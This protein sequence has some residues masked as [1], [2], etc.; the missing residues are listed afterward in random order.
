MGWF[1]VR[2]LPLGI[3]SF[4]KIVESNC[5][6]VDKTQFI[7]ELINSESYYFLS[8]PRRFGKSLLLDTLAEV[9]NGGKELFKGLWIYDSGYS[10]EEHPVLRI[11]MSNIANE[12]PETLKNE[13]MI[14][15]GRRAIQEGLS[16]DVET[17][18]AM[19]KTLIEELCSK[20]SQRVVVL[21]DEYD[22]PVLDNLHDLGIAEANRNVI[23]GFYGVL[24]SMDPY[25]RFTFITGITKF[26]KTSIFSGLN[27]LYDITLD[28]KYATICGVTI[29]DLGKCFS[30][31]I[32]GL[33][34]LE[35]FR[36]Y[37]SIN[38]GILAWYDGYSWDGESR[39]INPYSL[40]SFFT[41]KE[42]SGFW[43][44][45]GT[46]K[47][48]VDIIKND[49]S[50]YTNLKNFKMTELMLDSSDI[51]DIDAELLMFQTGYLTVK[52]KKHTG[53]EYVYILDMPN[54]EVR[55]AFDLHVL[56]AFSGKG[57]PR[58]KHAQMEIDDA[59]REGDLQRMLELLRGLF[60]S[61]PYQL[62]IDREAYYHSIFYAV[63]SVLGFDI[64]VEISAS[65]GRIDAVLELDNNIFVMEFKYKDC[66][67]GAGQETKRKLFDEA[68]T[69][70]MKQIKDMRYAGKYAGSGKS[71][72][73][74]VFA[75]L[76]RDEI[77]MIAETV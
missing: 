36:R 1:A 45:S 38:A 63:M 16:I 50:V 31:H 39:V 56:T 61:I 54:N 21:I 8:R 68:L 25:L 27:N 20:Y 23:R 48:L 60:A 65:R 10:F 47:F 44:A 77:E 34:P 12:T 37:S 6:Y 30:E 35:Y 24:K 69:E 26:T 66:A 3:Q 55:K 19:F 74:A 7:Y 40:L 4:R 2:K 13:L 59:L 76:G 43:Y 14:V 18:S 42:F 15:L 53:D 5:V 52:E 51:D 57:Q 9:F 72:C 62:H 71:V 58:V 17:P 49:P 41:R 64:D 73:M 32:E 29:E 70:G 67:P 33:A 11:D 22:K 46:P 75:F 28:K